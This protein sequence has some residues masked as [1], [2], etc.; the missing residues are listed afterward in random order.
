MNDGFMTLLAAPETTDVVARLHADLDE[1]ARVKTERL[2]ATGKA[3]MLASLVRAEAK[4]A[5]IKLGLLASADR[6]GTAAESGLASTDQWAARATNSDPVVVHRQVQLSQQLAE[7]T[8]TQRA[9][10]AGALS[11]EHAAVIVRA[12]SQLPAGVTTAQRAVVEQALIEKAAT[13]PPALLRRAARRVLAEVEPDTTIVD[14]HENDLVVDEERAARA[15]T[16]LS[17]HDNGDGT[18]TGHFTV[19]VL[20]GHLLRKILQTMTAPRRGRLGA[21]VAQVGENTGI[22]TDWDHARG[23]A[24]AEL[25]EHLPTD[26][27]HPRTAATV[28]VTMNQETLRDALAVAHLDTG[29]DISAGEARRLACNAQLLPAV[30]GGPSIPLDLGRS[31]RLFSEAQRTAL[32][33]RQQTC[34]AKGCDR[35]Y[36]WTEIHHLSSWATGG[37]TDLDNAIGLCHFHHQRIHDPAYDHELEPD[38]ITFHLKSRS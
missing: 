12:D 1:L 17:L 10:A 18:V 9:L 7:R 4:V 31:A 24:F 19:P 22:R 16:R 35:P 8:A 23:A 21:S 30:L 38:G 37:K 13:M 2:D 15:K 28:V 27:L 14:A 26:H 6:S 34:G 29:T 11:A 25:I 33:L 36:A 32:G 5:A 3:S 20:Q